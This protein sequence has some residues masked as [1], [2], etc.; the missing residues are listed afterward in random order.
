MEA[1]P[2]AK[3]ECSIRLQE[4]TVNI[5]SCVTRGSKCE[6]YEDLSYRPEK[7]VWENATWQITPSTSET[8]S[9]SGDSVSHGRAPKG[10]PTRKTSH[11]SADSIAS[12]LSRTLSPYQ[13]TDEQLGLRSWLLN[14]RSMGRS[15][16][17]LT[18]W[19][20]T[21]PTLAWSYEAVRHS[22]TAAGIIF[23][24]L[25]RRD[26]GSDHSNNEALALTYA[27]KAIRSVIEHPVPPEVAIV[28]STIFWVFDICTGHWLSAMKHLVAGH[29][30]SQ[31]AD[32]SRTSEPLIP[33]YVKS[34][35]GD[36]PAA[37]HPTN[38][39]ALP[40][41]EQKE[42]F[43]ARRAY[44][45]D[46]MQH[47]YDRTKEFQARVS[48]SPTIH[49]ERALRILGIVETELYHMVQRWPI[50]IKSRNRSEHPTITLQI[51]MKHSPF[52]PVL[53]HFE[54]FF[55]DDQEKWLDLFEVQFRPSL[56]ST[57]R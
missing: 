46:I 29:R 57:L 20:V 40:P 15:E 34:F 7:P 19:T 30:I 22:Q 2:S 31:T 35:I 28:I 21:I 49:K 8:T 14:I 55:L 38:I 54:M 17:G 18:Y 33:L 47:A 6:G 53:R 26:A 32:L 45:K 37:I 42:Q 25:H 56:D 39:M 11:Y 1:H 24:S 10:T 12:W 5:P 23:D 50:K 48:V 41:A 36:L 13:T 43:K 51:V 16:V 44:A 9:S 52:V 27:N 3:S 4:S